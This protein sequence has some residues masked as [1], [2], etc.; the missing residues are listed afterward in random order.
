VS[1]EPNP[2]DD[3]PSTGPAWDDTGCVKELLRE[4]TPCEAVPDL[5]VGPALDDAGSESLGRL[6]VDVGETGT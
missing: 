6:L 1:S 4:F 3:G 5:T 2:W